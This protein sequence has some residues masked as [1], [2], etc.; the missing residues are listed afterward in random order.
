MAEL[1]LA[2]LSVP[3]YSLQGE[4]TGEVKLPKVFE[5]PLRKDLIRR[6]FLSAFT[7]RLQP[8]GTDPLAGLRTTAESLGV[9]HGIARV[10]RIKGGLRA[11]R[12]PQAVKGRRA[13]PPKVEKKLHERIN[14]RERL[15]A[16]MSAIAA[17]AIRP[18]VEARGHLV[19]EK[20][21]PI[22]VDNS[23][24]EVSR[25]ADL[26][27]VLEKLGLWRDVE[28]AQRGTRVRAGKGKMRGRRYKVPVSVLIVVSDS[29][30]GILKAARNLPGVTVRTAKTVSVMD[31]APG[32]HP[33]RLTIY[34]VRALEEIRERFG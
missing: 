14:K 18:V 13:H 33:G 16:L 2:S 5:T 1:K 28:R 19:P 6:A 32:G 4:V 15:L 30:K 9:G 17:T 21:L 8:K 3:V 20:P 22:V 34:T 29:G 11:A 10:A 7:A 24:E 23:L 26:R 31:L 27:G 12:V 25:T